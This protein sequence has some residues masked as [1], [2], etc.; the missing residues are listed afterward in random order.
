LAT[1]QTERYATDGTRRN[2]RNYNATNGTEKRNHHIWLVNGNCSIREE[3]ASLIDFH[4]VKMVICEAAS[5]ETRC[6]CFGNRP[7]KRAARWQRREVA[8]A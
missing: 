8:M 1:Q 5:W 2:R 6:F 7:E 4:Y 3:D